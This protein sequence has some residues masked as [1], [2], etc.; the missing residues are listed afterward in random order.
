MTTPLLNIFLN[1]FAER[2]GANGYLNEQLWIGHAGHL[3]IVG[4]MVTAMLSALAYLGAEF[5]R[6][7]AAEVSWQKLGRFSYFILT[8]A[9]ISVFVL[10]F[11]MILNHRFEYHYAWRHSSRDLP[12]QYI[13]SSFWEGQEGSFLLWMFWLAVLGVTGIFTLRDYE[14]PTMAVVSLT[15]FFLSTMVLGVYVFG[16]KV[17]SSPFILLRD[18]MA[19]APIFQQKN[20]LDFVQ[21]GN[22]LNVL[23]QNYWMT[24][25]PPVLFLGFAAV[26]FPFSI[27][28]GGLLRNEHN[29]WVRH[30]LPWTLFAIVALGTGILMG[31]AW[32]YES[33]SFGGF[34]A[35]DP[36]EN[37]SLVPWLMLV[38]GLHTLLIYKNTKH[39]LIS[40]YLFLILA[41]LLV[42][43]STYLTRSGRLGDTS[44][45]SFTDD[46]LE[47]QLLAY[48]SFFFITSFTLLGIR[49]F[50]KQLPQPAREED[51]WSREFWM[52]IGTL[53]LLLSSVQM[54]ITTS[55]PIWNLLFYDKWRLLQNKIAP[56][57][58]AV[59]HYNSIQIWLGML[60]ACLTGAVQYLAYRSGKIPHI[61]R[62]AIYALAG[63]LVFAALIAWGTGVPFTHQYL[64]DLTFLSDKLFFKF[65]FV[66]P[67]FILLVCS[68]YALLGNLLYLVAVLKGNWRVSGGSVSH[69]GLGVFLVGVIISQGQKQVISTQ[70]VG[71]KDFDPK[72]RAENVLLLRDSTETMGDYLVT[73]TD[74]EV[75]GKSTFYVVKYQRRNRQGKITETFELRPEA[76]VMKDGN[77][78]ANP[79]T[80]HYLTRDVFTHITSVP[81]NR[82]LKD[83]TLVCSL[84]SGD[85]VKTNG[86]VIRFEG[87]EPRPRLPEGVD[88]AGKIAVGALLR[89]TT[90]GGKSYEAL[91]LFVIDLKTNRASNVPSHVAPLGFSFNVTNIDPKTQKVTLAIR[92][93][94]KESDFIIMKAIVFPYINLVWLGGIICFAGALL[95]MWQRRVRR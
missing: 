57:E 61:F 67:A 30:A 73:Y 3:M 12:L 59:A 13:I 20:Y 33:L 25:H 82:N 31:G 53:I 37:M 1:F 86:Y 76:S 62:W 14:N 15:Q 74:K 90:A 51:F 39:S 75:R 49:R 81:D 44:V 58:D 27:A 52:F 17:G 83:T 35:W 69:A 79:D 48:M 91:P 19:D 2:F 92:Y 23:L 46:G 16:F 4:I 54:L 64:I 22:G 34:W 60:M 88:S 56:P 93:R 78:N 68:V 11:I 24:I 87:F 45:H 21:D 43:Y 5:N 63:A 42:L 66:S 72:E 7:T 28:L 65:P 32:A 8:A 36:V 40:A 50:K 89:V 41:F 29:G 47:P 94:E 26:S 77:L 38:A 95:S 10:L 84:R 55:I 80:K 6:G 71:V 9:I 70:G 85:T 18:Q